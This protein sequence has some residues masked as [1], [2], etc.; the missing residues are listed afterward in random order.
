MN[1]NLKTE[2]FSLYITITVPAHS[3]CLIEIFAPCP[4]EN[5]RVKPTFRINLYTVGTTD[6]LSSG[7]LREHVTTVAY[8]AKQ[9][10]FIRVDYLSFT[11]KIHFFSVYDNSII[12]N[13]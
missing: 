6:R 10:D 12:I 4:V 1:T 3:T 2:R 9:Y 5:H 8:L 13:P 7:N 11:L